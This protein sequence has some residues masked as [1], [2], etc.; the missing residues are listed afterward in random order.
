MTSAT[1][2]DPPL[3]I[4]VGDFGRAMSRQLIAEMPSAT[5]VD[6]ATA[7]SADTSS[8]LVLATWREVPALARS[9]D[10]LPRIP[11]WIPVV[12]D[13]P[14]IRVGP[15]LG[16][17]LPGCYDCLAG[18]ML[19]AAENPALKRDMWDM[20]D[21]D[22]ALGIHGY[23]EHH[24]VIAASLTSA[25]CRSAPEALREVQ[26]YDVLHG[27]LDRHTFVPLPNC[28]RWPKT[29]TMAGAVR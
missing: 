27:T 16:R 15:V 26:V 25:L 4:P 21:H 5:V 2:S 23:L 29:S 19:S 17:N 18:R 22:S 28:E 24:A 3:V 9:L 8:P 11:W 7:C 13:H 6:H 20:Y 14:M 10:R 1:K 12:Y